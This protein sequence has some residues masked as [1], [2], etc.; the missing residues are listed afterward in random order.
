MAPTAQDPLPA[1]ISALGQ[2]MRQIAA[3]YEAVFSTLQRNLAA[4]TASA[5]SLAEGARAAMALADAAADALVTH[6]PNQPV[7]ACQAG[8]D[9]CCH[10][11]VMV[12]PGVAEAISGFLV[13]RLDPAAL[14]DLRM[15]LQQAAKAADA[16][17]DPTTLR[18]RCPLLGADGLCTV[19]EVR[20]P[21]CRAFTSSAV[22]ACRALAFDPNGAGAA[23]PQNPSQ[24]RVYVEATAA[25]EQAARAR[26]ASDRQTG[27]AAALLAVLPDG[28]G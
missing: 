6:L 25:L 9:A 14:T 10:L 7:R 24:Y 15:E 23:I 27:L 11:Y 3:R 13:E 17:A 21:T 5:P 28:A 1:E 12:P 22:A 20:P 18:R 19:Y 4:S 16:L 2:Q 8:C 26:G